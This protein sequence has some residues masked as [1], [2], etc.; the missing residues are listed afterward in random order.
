MT[1]ILQSA[2]Q[3]L[4]LFF[5]KRIWPLVQGLLSWIL[6]RIFAK[7]AEK[8]RRWLTSRLE[9]W[10]GEAT[11]KGRTEGEQAQ[12]ATTETEKLKAEARA[13]VWKEIAEQL[14]FENQELRLKLE[15]LEAFSNKDAPPALTKID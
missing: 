10:E 15:R 6:D 11:S 5:L 1:P 12:K 4:L 7:S 8:I 13:D 14:R 9:K 3:W 2:A